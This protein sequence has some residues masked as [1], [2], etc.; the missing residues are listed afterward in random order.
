M[1]TFADLFAEFRAARKQLRRQTTLRGAGP[2]I[3]AFAKAATHYVAASAGSIR[4][5]DHQWKRML[6]H[7]L[8]RS[9]VD[10]IVTGRIEKLEALI[11]HWLGKGLTVSAVAMGDAPGDRGSGARARRVY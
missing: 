10:A 6:P 9:E 1:A 5:W 3:P 7:P 11:A 2:S 4:A 8:S